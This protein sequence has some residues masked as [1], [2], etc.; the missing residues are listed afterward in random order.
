MARLLAEA[1]YAVLDAPGPLRAL[2]LARE[3]SGRIRLLVSDIRMP[4]MTGVEL[5]AQFHQVVPT[6]GIVLMSGFHDHRELQHPF[7]AKPFTSDELLD[8]VVGALPPTG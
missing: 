2:E 4:R 8:A 5:A 6:A 3:H 7:L 1:G